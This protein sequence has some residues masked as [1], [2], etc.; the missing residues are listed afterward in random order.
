MAFSDFL[1]SVVSGSSSFRA[2]VYKKSATSFLS[3][4]RTRGLDPDGDLQQLAAEW[5]INL[6]L[7]GHSFLTS[8]SYFNA[9]S[10][11]AK[12]AGAASQTGPKAAPQDATQN[13]STLRARLKSDGESLWASGPDIDGL[14]KFRD[15]LRSVSLTP[16]AALDILRLSMANG[17]MP[18]AEVAA[19]RSDDLDAMSAQSREIALRHLDPR[20]K[21]VFNL[22]QSRLTPRQLRR[23]T[24]GLVT[25]LLVRNSLPVS[26][27]P[28][29]TVA[30]Y[31]ALA[32]LGCDISG[33]DVNA[34][35]GQ[36]APGI[37][38]LG[39]TPSSGISD[40]EKADINALVAD[41]FVACQAKWYV[42]KLRPRVKFTDIVA[43][44]D[45][46]DASIPRPSMFYP[47]EE[48]MK[49][50]GRKLVSVTKPVIPDIVFF[51]SRESEIRHIF[52][53]IGD[54]AWCFTVSGRPGDA[55]A[56]V[57][58]AAFRM[59]QKTIGQF[60]TDYQVAP[61]GTLSLQ[62][63]DRVVVV[64]G[65]F[66]GETGRIDKIET[67][68]AAC[69]KTEASATEETTSTEASTLYRLY[70]TKDNGIEWRLTLPRPLLRKQ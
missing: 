45:L 70:I 2:P 7:T 29:H 35:L 53:L 21:Y 20:R 30:A 61:L 34:V 59:F 38:I 16:D 64:G 41:A 52:S 56:S 60:T 68:P 49:R 46:L 19:L 66:E 55:Y 58:D 25:S 47:C 8:L 37:E 18:L 6:W 11:I 23:Y 44:L 22:S 50:V 36:Q 39:L 43:R 48:I 51:K 28:D 9:L 62:V 27:T 17:A 26:D 40:A 42:M 3:F 67:R 4:L 24:S 13:L 63:N 14:A 57:P 5:L 32:A 33:A 1:E 69:G 12:R 31:W 54:L 10:G 65:I 15:L